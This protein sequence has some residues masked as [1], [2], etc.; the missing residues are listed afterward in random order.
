MNDY[1]NTDTQRNAADISNA[2][3]DNKELLRVYSISKIVHEYFSQNSMSMLEASIFSYFF[4]KQYLRYLDA[5][6]G[7]ENDIIVLLNAFVNKRIALESPLFSDKEYLMINPDVASVGTIPLLHYALHGAKENRNVSR[8]LKNLDLFAGVWET[9]LKYIEY[10]ESYNHDFWS[11]IVDVDFLK[12]HKFKQD[13]TNKQMLVALL[14]ENTPPSRLFNISFYQKQCEIIGLAIDMPDILHYMSVGWKMGLDPSPFFDTTFYC[15]DN[16]GCNLEEVGSDVLTTFLSDNNGE[17]VSASPFMDL[18]FLRHNMQWQHD[19]KYT[20][21]Q[22]MVADL[23]SYDW[24]D[25]HPHVDRKAISVLVNVDEVFSPKGYNATVNDF[26]SI[27]G[28]MRLNCLK[29]KFQDKQKQLDKSSDIKISIIILNYNKPVLALVST[30]AAI[31]ASR[32]I[33]TEIILVDNGSDPFSLELLY[34]YAPTS[35]YLKILPLAKNKFFGEG[36]NIALDDSCGDMVLFLNND[37]F[38][39]ANTLEKLSSLLC[40]KENLGAISPVLMFNDMKI[41]EAGGIISECGQVIQKLKYVSF[42]RYAQKNWQ[43]DAIDTVDYVSA[44]C[45]LVKRDV[46]KK[47]LGFDFYYEPFYYEDTDFCA[48]IKA[49]GYL[50]G[51]ATSVY[52]IHLENASTKEFLGDRMGELISRQRS[53]FFDRWFGIYSKLSSEDYCKKTARFAVSQQYEIVTHNEAECGY[54][55]K[56][57]VYIYTPFDINIGGGERYI[58]SLAQELSQDFE[59]WF[60]TKTRTSRARMSMILADLDIPPCRLHLATLNDIL[61]A[62]RPDYFFCMGNEIDPPVPPIGKKNIY[63]CQFPFPVHCCGYFELN[64]I[65]Q[66]STIVVNSDFTKKHVML[67]LNKYNIPMKDIHVVH[68]PIP[69]PSREQQAAIMT[70]KLSQFKTQSVVNVGRFFKSGHT[71]R[72]D[73]VISIAQKCFEANLSL[74][75]RLCGGLDTEKINIEYFQTLKEMAKGYDIELAPNVSREYLNNIYTEGTFYLHTCGYGYSSGIA[76]E[77]TEHFGITVIEAMSYGLIPII[78]KW[79]GLSDVIS[80][81]GVGL[82]FD[83]TEDVVTFFKQNYSFSVDFVA[84][85]MRNCIDFS[86]QYRVERFNEQIRAIFNTI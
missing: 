76:P 49:Q 44:A 64:N 22:R 8:L 55:G 74:K 18:K 83:K 63:H 66:Y 78:Y 25:F 62:V 1:V 4:D 29:L 43:N 53:K 58:L 38:L 50:L 82:T 84:E 37:C 21:I 41:Q 67:N 3:V 69:I 81:S 32:N 9:E 52:A 28:E 75:F 57:T 47:V 40:E 35:A 70:A 39:G 15:I 51:V 27:L 19:Y 17:M 11:P 79:G 24:V 14:S 5:N 2:S 46:L 33:S 45:C 26:E 65:K 68:P 80:N 36:N 23:F 86:Q 6:L 56:P 72:Q 10:L 12:Q 59:V 42:D 13:V 73:L 85:K 71:K 30:Y 54:S 60:L 7:E 16:K 34:R 77:R 31:R 61:M 48:R 20:T